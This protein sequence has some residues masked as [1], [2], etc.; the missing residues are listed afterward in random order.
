[1]QDINWGDLFP[2]YDKGF[3]DI[4]RVLS[5]QD[6]A[7]IPDFQQKKEDVPEKK[8][9]EVQPLKT[10]SQWHKLTG[11]VM[12]VPKVKP[13]PQPQALKTKYQLRKE[14][15]TVSSKEALKAFNLKQDTDSWWRP[16]EY[17]QNDFRDNGD[18]TII[19]LAT[20]L[21]WQKSGSPKDINYGEAKVYIKKLNQEK[22]AGYRDWRLPTVDEL[23]FLLTSEKQSNGLYIN[24][25]F[26][27]NQ[28]CF[29]TSDSRASGG[30]WRVDFSYG[31]VY[32]YFLGGKLYVRA[33]RSVK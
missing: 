27:K 20:D 14:P 19:D 4:L 7:D 32:W 30:V 3:Q 25:I 8:E 23:K 26:G 18:G 17:I 16:L 24:P 6:A 5:R 15:I 1:M 28:S 10:E 2:S 9:A 13:T 12:P 11:E 22:F 31:V 29:W 21:M 33:V